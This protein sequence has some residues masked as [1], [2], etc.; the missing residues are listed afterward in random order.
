[1]VKLQRGQ[2]TSLLTRY[3]PLFVLMALLLYNISAVGKALKAVVPI[4][5]SMVVRYE[6]WGIRAAL[7]ANFSATTSFPRPGSDFENFLRD[8]MGKKDLRDPT[9]DRFGVKYAYTVLTT[10]TGR[11]YGFRIV[12]AG[13]D[14]WFLTRD[15]IVVDW[16]TAIP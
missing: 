1:M 2:I 7:V 13:P 15:D 4:T 10:P 16:K 11:E 14:R 6:M 9:K 5:M 3:T 8:S 12:S